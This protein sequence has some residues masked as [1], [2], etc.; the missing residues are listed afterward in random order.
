[1]ADGFNSRSRVGSDEPDKA[2][3]QLLMGFQFALPRGERRSINPL[4]SS[5]ALF[6]FALPRGERRAENHARRF[7]LGFNS[8]SRVGSDEPDKANPQ[9]LMGFQF[10]LP[11]GERRG[12]RGVVGVVTD[13]SIRAPA[14]GATRRNQARMRRWHRFNS[15]SR[16]GSD[17]AIA[18]MAQVKPVS[19]RAPAW[20]ATRRTAGSAGARRGFNSRSRVGSD[21]GSNR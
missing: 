11:R 1:M 6:Q 17:S 10:A 13:V 3:P 4:R 9:L 20:G 7:Q 15:R 21:S 5:E 18:G 19:I 16:V 2:N 14:W 8:R 12:L